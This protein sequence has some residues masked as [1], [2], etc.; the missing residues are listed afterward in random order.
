MALKRI[1]RPEPVP[2]ALA[3]LYLCAFFDHFSM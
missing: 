1:P 3:A 2:P